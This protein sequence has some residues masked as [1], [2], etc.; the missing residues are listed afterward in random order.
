MQSIWTRVAVLAALAAAVALFVVLSGGND[1][2][3]STETT[4]ETV[5]GATTPKPPLPVIEV[6]NGEPVGGVERIDARRGERVSFEVR[7]APPEEEIHVHG[8]EITEPAQSGRVR[9]S[10]PADL[11]GIFEVEVHRRDGSEVQIAELRVSP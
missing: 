5:T 11:D 1:D 9:V 2:D 8:Y 10:F 6:R 3:S 7:L 4:V